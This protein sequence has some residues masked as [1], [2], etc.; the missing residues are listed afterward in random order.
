MM[1]AAEKQAPMMARIFPSIIVL[2]NKFRV[3]RSR[4][5]RE[6][7]CF[8]DDCKTEGNWS[9]D[10]GDCHIF[11]LLWHC[12]PCE[13]A[14]ECQDKNDPRA[15]D[16]AEELEELHDVFSRCAVDVDILSRV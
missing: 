2:E 14:D 1:N 16:D 5:F 7:N 15:E 13:R 11:D 8:Q 10:D 6:S 9:C 4:T 3:R 12:I